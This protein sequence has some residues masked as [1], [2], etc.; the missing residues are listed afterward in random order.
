MYV[1]RGSFLDRLAR[2]NFV[3]RTQKLRQLSYTFE[4]NQLL[5]HVK[6]QYLLWIVTPHEDCQHNAGD[7]FFLQK[8]QSSYTH[9]TLLIY[10]NESKYWS[11][12]SPAY[13][14]DC[15]VT[16][17][18][19][20]SVYEVIIQFSLHSSFFPCHCNG[21]EFCSFLNE[22]NFKMIGTTFIGA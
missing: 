12:E 16:L 15:F 3:Q 19:Y 6:G 1:G 2:E 8:L 5:I 21:G 14:I 9:N 17:Q 20:F 4:K 13:M 7:Y 10:L 18:M 11:S 22:R